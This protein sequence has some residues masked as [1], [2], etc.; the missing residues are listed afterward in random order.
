MFEPAPNWHLQSARRNGGGTAARRPA[1]AQ[2][3]RRRTTERRAGCPTMSAAASLSHQQWE[4]QLS[5]II[6]R[7]NA[8]LNALSTRYSPAR[9]AESVRR[10]AE[11]QSWDAFEERDR[12]PVPSESVETF[13]VDDDAIERSRDV[14]LFA[15]D[16]VVDATV[17]MTRVSHAVARERWPEHVPGDAS[18]YVEAMRTMRRAIAESTSCEAVVM[19]RVIADEAIIGGRTTSGGRPG[20]VFSNEQRFER[21]TRPLTVDEIVSSWPEIKL[22]SVLKWGEEVE[23][24]VGWDGRRMMPAGLQASVDARRMETTADGEPG[25]SAGE[26]V[27]YEDLKPLLHA[28]LARGSK[29]FVLNSRGRAVERCRE[30]FRENGFEVAEDVDGYGVCVIPT[31]NFA[32]RSLAAANLIATTARPGEHW[33]IIDGDMDEL[34]R[35]KDSDL[36]EAYESLTRGVEVTLRHASYAYASPRATHRAHLDR[37]IQSLTADSAKNLALNFL[38]GFSQVPNR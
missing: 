1:G 16:A 32:S 9:P 29:V 11:R 25:T 37:E 6:E 5:G 15:Y 28:A 27:V 35:F 7:T 24:S 8:N 31:E 4:Q 33:H 10:S 2:A 30:I 38:G 22:M 20:P 17:E 26:Q 23:S 14:V 21:R 18:S 34:E 13:A 36:G 3:A 19:V 12:R